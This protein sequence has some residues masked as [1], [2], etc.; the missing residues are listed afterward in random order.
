MANNK[1]GGATLVETMIEKYGSYEAFR[2]SMRER[3]SKGGSVKGTQ[4]GFAADNNR[5]RAS[6]AIGGKHSRRGHKLIK[7][8]DT[9]GL[10]INNKSG[11]IVRINYV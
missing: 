10:Y 3:A 11:S 6:G 2:E 8:H 1:K 7:R 9:Y 4:G 5:A